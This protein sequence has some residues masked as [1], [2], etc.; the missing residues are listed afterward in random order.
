[1]SQCEICSLGVKL[2]IYEGPIRL[3]QLGHYSDKSYR[4][5]QCG[6]CNVASLDYEHLNYETDNYRKSVDGESSAGSFYKQH[7]KEQL[8]YLRMLGTELP[9]DATV[10]DVGCGGGSFLDYMSGVASKTIGVEPG[11]FFHS[12]LLSRGHEVY[13]Y[14]ENCI[15][16]Y[17]DTV[18]L[19]VSFNVIEHVKN[20]LNFL[21]DMYRLLR[22]GGTL[23][24]CTPNLDNW[25]IN[26][27]PDK[28]SKF[29]YRRVH[30]WYFC[31]KSL[32]NMCNLCDIT[33]YSVKYSQRYG[34]ANALT[35]IR[36]GRGSGNDATHFLSGLDGSYKQFV[37]ANE[38]ADLIYLQCRKASVKD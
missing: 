4:V 1:M 17:A 33:D 26:F 18:D 25:L 19:V 21:R 13:P 35:W 30:P 32:E 5:S 22:P 2:P 27:A 36:E 16:R 12:S 6:Q 24:L 8:E 29:F 23:L 9:R 20:P 31:K 34:L 10:C 14:M 3:G 38:I 11:E 28:F 7:D 15:E 37:E